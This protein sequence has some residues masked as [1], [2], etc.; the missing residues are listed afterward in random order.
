MRVVQYF[1]EKYQYRLNYVALPCVQAGSDSKPIY[2]PMEVCSLLC[3][4]ISCVSIPILV[5][6][7][8]ALYV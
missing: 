4:A 6:G 5:H 1:Q 2:L 8:T 7:C 3:I